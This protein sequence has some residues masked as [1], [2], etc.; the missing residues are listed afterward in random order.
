[1]HKMFVSQSHLSF[2]PPALTFTCSFL[3]FSHF[4]FL[5]HQRPPSAPAFHYRSRHFSA[6]TSDRVSAR[7]CRSRVSMLSTLRRGPSAPNTHKLPWPVAPSDH[8]LPRTVLV[9]QVARHATHS[10]H[11]HTSTRTRSEP[12]WHWCKVSVLPLQVKSYFYSIVGLFKA[13]TI[14]IPWTYLRLLIMWRLISFSMDPE[15]TAGSAQSGRWS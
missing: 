5:L 13:A 10:E 15:Q 3:A 7:A 8:L 11:T 2:F 6:Y 1:M 9:C 12:P 14:V 4:P